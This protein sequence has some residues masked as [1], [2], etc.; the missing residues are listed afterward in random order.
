MYQGMAGV[1]GLPRGRGAPPPRPAQ[2]ARLASVLSEA[3]ALFVALWVKVCSQTDWPLT[4][5][6]TCGVCAR[7]RAL[8]CAAL[9]DRRTCVLRLT[10]LSTLHG[11]HFALQLSLR[12]CRCVGTL[13]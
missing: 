7:P 8:P 1:A 2:P 3:R 5:D 13:A 10:G 6:L 12:A 11:R 9:P 4:I